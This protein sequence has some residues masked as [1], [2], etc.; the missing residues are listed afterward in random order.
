MF[1]GR[2]CLRIN[3]D[4]LGVVKRQDGGEIVVAV[5]ENIHLVVVERA[6]DVPLFNQLKG[7]EAISGRR[8]NTFGKGQK[9][10]PSR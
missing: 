4:H 2:M 5:E 1:D 3:C 8:R 9:S 6:L 7:V 10:T